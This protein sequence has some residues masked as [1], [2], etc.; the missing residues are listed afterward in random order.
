MP[1]TAPVRTNVS[2]S[3]ITVAQ[4]GFGTINILD[5][6]N[7]YLER[8]KSFSEIE[9][10][11]LVFPTYSQAY[12]AIAAA[13]S[14]DPKPQTVMVTRR[15]CNATLTVDT[16]SNGKVY[17]V[18]IR[19]SASVFHNISYTASGVDTATTVAAALVSAINGVTSLA[20]I[21]TASNSAGVVTIVRDGVAD[22]SIDMAGLSNLVIG[23]VSGAEAFATTMAA[24]LGETEEFYA[25]STTD[26]T[27]THL[28]QGIAWVATQKRV[29]VFDTAE[30]TAYATDF[31]GSSTDWLA[32]PKIAG[33]KRV[34]PVFSQVDQHDLFPAIRI[35]AEKSSYQPGDVIYSNIANLG[36][37][38]A[39]NASGV[40]L[41]SVEK[42][43]LMDRGIAY[44]ETFAKVTIARRG[45]TQGAGTSSWLDETIGADFIE[46]RVNEAVANL[47]FNRKSDKIGGSARGYGQIKSVIASTLDAMKSSG[48]KA[49]LLRKYE[50]IVPS[51]KDI[52]A[53]IR[54]GRKA[55][56]TVRAWLEGAIDSVEVN[57]NLT[58]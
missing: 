10:A 27:Q 47:L 34:G 28:E 21:V 9:E 30:A 25:V 29:F 26:R 32:L 13:F 15:K 52:T 56:V 19:E 17:S 48:D 58:N 4:R 57:V 54:A 39:K 55:T 40:L 53:A 49:R 1:Y 7:Q 2:S 44:F 12:K 33:N 3:T 6:H 11:A 45:T 24:A 43:R 41:T 51:E 22:F 18:R 50:I 36:V 8:T 16:P 14:V 23:K 5:E 38:P 46:A 37:L 42:G 31:S 35:F 20:A